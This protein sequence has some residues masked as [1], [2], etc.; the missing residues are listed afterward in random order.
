VVVAGTAGYGKSSLISSWLAQS[1]PTGAVAWLTIDASDQDVGRLTADLLGALRA[2]AGESLS[3]ALQELQ[4]PPLF[5]DPLAFI[6]S[7]HEALYE[8]DVPLTLVLDDLQHLSTSERAL[9]VVDHL[10][11]WAPSITRVIL[12]GRTV[13][14][15]RLQR[16]RLEDR[17]E[18]IGHRDLAFTPE[19]TD[20]AVSA[21]GLE[22]S[23][24]AIDTLHQVTQGW[25]AAVRMAVLAMRAGGDQN[26]SLGLRR[27]DALA[28]YLTTEVLAAIDDELRRFLLDATIDDTVCPSLVDAVLGS[29]NGEALLERC[30]AEGL[31]LTREGRPGVGPWYRW[32]SLFAAHMRGRRRIED[33]AR[34]RALELRAAR[35]WSTVDAATAVNHALDGGH[36]ELA[37]GILASSWLGLAL[38][39]RVETV[40]SLVDSI[41]SDVGDAGELNLALAF[42]AAQAGRTEAAR[43]E[44]AIARREAERLDEVARARFE[45]RATVIDIFLVNDRAALTEA[46][47]SGRAL[48]RGVGDGPWIP[49]RATLA[50]VEL[51]VGK[52]LARL[53]QD[54]PHALQL[55]RDAAESAR[56]AGL[57]AL[58]LAALAETCIPSIAEGDLEAT[59]LLALR[60]L[61]NARAKGWGDLSS[62]APAHAYLG[63]FYLWQGD[64]RQAREHLARAL[65]ILLPTDWGLRGVILAT[66]AQAC[67]QAG[68]VV[69]AAADAHQA[70]ELATPER[71]PP[72]WPSLLSALDSIICM[73]Q[74]DVDEAVRSAAEPDPGP[75]YHL[76]VCL[77]ANILLQ[78]GRPRDCLDMVTNIPP[79]WRFPH[80]VVLVEV[81]RAQALHDLGDKEGSH[82]ALERALSAATP[83]QLVAP[84]FLVG[85]ALLPLVRD[86]LHRGTAYPEF[87]PLI[88]KRL[89][90]T[91]TST[92][93][94]YGETLTER[95]HAILR[96]LA[97]SLSNAEIADAEFISVNTAK[98]H[99]AHIY[100]K[101]GV[102]SRRSA[103]RRAGELDL[104]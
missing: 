102:S 63:W 103:V 35:W 67:L 30:A 89:A 51:Y 77:R 21:S 79:G 15:L 82:A 16:L 36:P 17:L 100:R 95:E 5:A 61:A 58:E 71:M 94:E 19:E 3:A 33:P 9:E 55:L 23:Q 74:G 66:H 27:D 87:V 64:A 97:T 10:L 104:I 8:I 93:N 41:P 86:H 7:I 96:Y 90:T 34:S 49:D 80:V 42:V 78:A 39:G 1:G 32:H 37:G 75:S 98:T 4:A 43:V 68:D 28:E 44:L 40:V 76:A 25:P 62:V 70:Q 22:M 65:S 47:A 92:V 50:L 26:L 72:W 18:L 85:P 101:L 11:R 6:D 14:R 59:R 73:A 99:M 38:E 69:A 52:G 57:S 45:I 46:V 29:Q 53:Q 54:V 83:F 60:V 12:S 24:D 88:L 20:A 31:F 91:G 48:L 2:S 13:P 81:L 56:A 84:F